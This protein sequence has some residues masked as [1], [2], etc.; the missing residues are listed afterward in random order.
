MSTTSIGFVLKALMK[1]FDLNALDLEK[2]TAIPSSTIYRLLKNKDGNPTVDVLKK[3]A[4]FFQIT[5]SQ[6]IGEEPLGVKQLPLVP[7][8]DILKFISASVEEKSKY[9]SISIDFPLN[10]KSF[11]TY[12][13]DDFMEP[14]ILMNSII[15]VDPVREISHKDIVLFINKNDSIPKIR[16]IVKDGQDIY[17]KT[18]NSSLAIDVIKI[19]NIRK[20]MFVGVIVH[21]RTNLFTFEKCDMTQDKTKLVH[22]E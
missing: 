14:F 7:T 22:F 21:Y 8:L 6:L 13:Q 12:V 10:S 5:V 15:I 18:L 17:F 16:Q 2:H 4:T 1:K 20:F 11:A 19:K 9:Q 3:L